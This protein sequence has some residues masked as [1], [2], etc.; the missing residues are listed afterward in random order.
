M[1]VLT[2]IRS[3]GGEQRRRVTV[4]TRRWSAAAATTAAEARRSR[5][6]VGAVSVHFVFAPRVLVLA[7]YAPVQLFSRARVLLFGNCL[8][9]IFFLDSFFLS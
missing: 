8:P 3:G 2:E 9:A 7:L 1:G 6:S 5:A 4:T